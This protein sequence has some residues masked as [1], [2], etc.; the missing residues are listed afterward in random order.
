M[1]K[2]QNT[3]RSSYIR[4]IFKTMQN[5]TEEMSIVERDTRTV[6]GQKN[7]IQKENHYE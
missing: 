7:A 6:D 1:L 5:D 3:S 4:N 2:Y